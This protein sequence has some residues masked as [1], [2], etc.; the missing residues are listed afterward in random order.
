[1]SMHFDMATELYG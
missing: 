1:M